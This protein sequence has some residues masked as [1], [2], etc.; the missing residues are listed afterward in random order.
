MSTAGEEEARSIFQGDSGMFMVNWPYVYAAA[1]GDG[2]GGPLDQSVVDDIGWARYPGVDGRRGR[3]PAARR[4]QPGH[5]RLHQ[6][7][8]RRRSPRSSASPRCESNV[9]YMVDAGN[10]AA[11]SAAA[12]DD[13]EVREAFPMAALIR[14]SID[15]AGPRPVTPV[16]RRRLD[17]GAADLAPG[18]GGPGSADAGGDR[19]PS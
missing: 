4:D 16:L 9:E 12:Y 10:P 2:R 17:L 1:Q 7:P 14:D 13:P 19:R 8:G 5:R 11:R 18:D 6:V 15:E 3:A